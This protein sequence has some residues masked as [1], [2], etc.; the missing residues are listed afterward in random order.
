MWTQIK[1]RIAPLE[2]L[3]RRHSA[4]PFFLASS[5]VMMILVAL[6]LRSVSLSTS[7]FLPFGVACGFMIFFPWFKRLDRSNAFRRIV[8]EFL[9]PF[10]LGDLLLLASSLYLNL[11]PFSGP[12][13]QIFFLYLL[14]FS[15]F[16]TIYF[17]KEKVEQNL[18]RERY[19]ENETER[20]RI[21]SFAIAEP[22]RNRIPLIKH[23]AKWFFAEGGFCA[24]GLIVVIALGLYLRLNGIGS[25]FFWIDESTSMKVAQRIAEGKGQTLMNGLFYNRGIIYHHY[26]GLLIK[27]VSGNLYII[28]RVANVPFFIAIAVTVYYFGKYITDKKTGLIASALFCFSWIGISIFREARFYEMWLAVYTGFIFLLTHLLFAY[29]R[30]TEHSVLAF[31]NRR[32]LPFFGLFCLGV[33]SYDCQ[34][35]TAFILYPLIVFG[36]LVF[37]FRK[38][39]KG[40][41]ISL[42]SFAALFAALTLKYHLS[43]FSRLIKQSGPAW[44]SL[45]PETPILGLWNFLLANDYKYL[46]IIVAFLCVVGII[47]RKNLQLAFIV[48]F[49]FTWY[50]ILA[51]QGYE[52]NMIRYYYPILP[53]LAIG[54]AY[55]FSICFAL[56]A[57]QPW[58]QFVTYG[59]LIAL[60]GSSFASGVQESGSIPTNNSKYAFK[61]DNFGNE[62]FY[63]DTYA[64]IDHS[65]VVTNSIW[66]LPYDIYFNR[67]PD[68]IVFDTSIVPFDVSQIDPMTNRPE[69]NFSEIAA[70]KRP[71][72]VI[73]NYPSQ[74]TSPEAF[75]LMNQMG[76]EVFRDGNI[77]IFYVK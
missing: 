50:F 27:Y 51:A 7:F 5:V 6:N 77:R 22:L 38:E 18:C 4:V 56:F 16:L 57:G 14:V 24:F 28:G 32:K 67:P 44:K 43:V 13:M 55:C 10:F 66:A 64:D 61:N 26:I 75:N 34:E 49:A 53:I 23:V 46:I 9:G 37:V 54:V 40:I 12:A 31:V 48:S 73:F 62:L 11:G 47:F 72:Y 20:E 69:L 1:N 36:L 17:Q 71:M 19:K 21:A 25:L 3:V 8:L 45:Y 74:R 39:V 35:L 76:R 65:T 68:G 30:E 63:L 41:I 70:L 58:R 59:L 52:V 42:F 29:L 33:L 2:T 15:G 60:L